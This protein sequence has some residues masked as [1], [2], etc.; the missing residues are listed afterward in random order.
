MQLSFFH[1]FKFVF[2]S[3]VF[4]PCALTQLTAVKG[5]TMVLTYLLKFVIFKWTA[6]NIQTSSA[7]DGVVLSCLFISKDLSPLL[8]IDQECV[9]SIQKELI[10]EFWPGGNL[11]Y[12]HT[13]TLFDPLRFH[14]CQIYFSHHGQSKL[15]SVLRMDQSWKSV[16]PHYHHEV[17]YIFTFTVSNGWTYMYDWQMLYP[18]SISYD[19]RKSAWRYQIMLW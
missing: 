17:Y 7:A 15:R 10:V 11:T 8:W 18:F 14:A 13:L 3:R 5:L 6:N 19:G 2:F 16:Y 1:Y 4:A 12:P 9:V